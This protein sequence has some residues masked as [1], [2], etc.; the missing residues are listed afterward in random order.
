MVLLDVVRGGRP[1]LAVEKP[2]IVYRAQGAETKE[3]YD[4]YGY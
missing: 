3:I 4:V 2:L 1:R